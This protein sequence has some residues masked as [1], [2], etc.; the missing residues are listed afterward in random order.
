MTSRKSNV[1]RTLEMREAAPTQAELAEH[2]D[3][4]ERSVRQVLAHAGIKHGSATLSEVRIAYIHR[5]RKSA[6]GHGAGVVN[7]EEIDLATER[8]LLAREQRIRLEMMNAEKRSTLIPA[9]KI[10]PKIRAMVVAAREYWRGEP[11]RIA[12]EV[13]GMGEDDMRK[14]MMLAFDAFLARLAGWNCEGYVYGDGS[15]EELTDDA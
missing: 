11:A 10:E 3:M 6:A 12:R 4:S 5:L 8:A 14:T 15:T 13:K 7:G 1:P 2:L 9:D